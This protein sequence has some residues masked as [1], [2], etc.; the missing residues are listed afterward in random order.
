MEPPNQPEANDPTRAETDRRTAPEAPAGAMHA[1]VAGLAWPGLPPS[2]HWAQLALQLQLEQTQWWPQERLL[3]CQ[4]A[5][6][7]L[8]LRHAGASVPYYR[9]LFARIGF[10]TAAALRIEDWRRLPI[11]TRR[12][13][14]E[15]NAALRSATLPASHGA[16]KDSSSSGSTGTPI[17][18]AKTGLQALFAQVG[19]LRDHLWHRRDLS[20]RFASIRNPVEPGGAAY[21][22]GIA[23]TRW[24]PA[25]AAFH[26]GPGF[27][28]SISTPIDRQVEWLQRVRP[29]YLLSFPSNLGALAQ[30]CLD[31]GTRLPFLRELR[32]ISEVL[33]P[34]IRTLCRSAFG[35]EIKDVYSAGETGNIALQSPASEQL[36]VQAE[37]MMVEIIG[38]DGRDC[39]PGETGS[40]VVTPL[41]GFAMP[42]LRYAIGDYAEAGGRAAC[43]RGLPVITR[44]LGRLRHMVRLPDGRTFY[45]NYAGLTKGLDKILQFQIARIAEDALEARLVVR[46]PLGPDEEAVLR[47]RIQD[48]FLH[49]FVVSIRYLDAIARSRSGKYFDYVPM[50]DEDPP[51]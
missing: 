42:L 26:T 11:L 10:D 31:T 27:T 38:P 35:V 20:L 45:P 32:T 4:L 50:L 29:D 48:R 19:N 8:L 30:L 21:P 28:L 16:A 12:D 33:K 23:S 51:A 43:G 37:T 14:Q 13:V 40:V 36:L 2:A 1:S 3:A 22:A 39:G 15:H 47:A 7:Q 9:D 46:A 41:H 5:Q 18:F 25:T 44:I 34:E 24:G 6:L 17:R 49:P